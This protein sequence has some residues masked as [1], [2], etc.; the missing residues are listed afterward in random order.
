MKCAN[1]SRDGMYV[2]RITKTTSVYYCSKDLPSFL[3]DRRKA[4][5]LNITEAFTEAKESVVEALKL[6]EV[7]ETVVEPTP[8]PKKKTAK[9]TED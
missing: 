7:Q 4:G 2:Y 5:L 1:C 6:P 8:V 9:K 3:E